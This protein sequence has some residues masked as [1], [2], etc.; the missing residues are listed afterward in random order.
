MELISCLTVTQQGRLME[1]GRSIHCFS[2]QSHENKEMVIVHDGD[3]ATHLAVQAL[4]A[5]H[6]GA[7]FVL[8][9]ESVCRS[10]GY[11]RN[12]AVELANG[13]IVCQWDDDDLN[14]PLRL[15]RQYQR[16]QEQQAD[17]C[18]FTDQLHWFEPSQELYWDD[19]NVERYPMNLI[20]GTLMGRRDYIGRY[21]DLA[22]GED[23]PVVLD[24]VRRC[25]ITA[26]RGQG[27]LYVYVYNG[28]NAWDFRHHAAISA[29]KRLRLD[30]LTPRVSTLTEYLR[31]YEWTI[32]KLRMPHDNG[33]LEIDLISD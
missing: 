24:I 16:L 17:F 28:K 33:V 6:P 18:L 23:T 22:R 25:K 7:R 5:E 11:L 32:N 21:P 20:Q 9:Q 19:W 4:V 29:W 3:D 2:S 27:Y 14:H 30:D 15:E 13:S 12:I 10:L 8:H 31:G 1:L 26:L